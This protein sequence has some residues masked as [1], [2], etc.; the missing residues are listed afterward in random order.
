MDYYTIIGGDG[1]EYGP[2]SEDTIRDWIRQGRANALT[3]ASKGD[4]APHPLSEFP[5]FSD[6]LGGTVGASPTSGIKLSKSSSSSGGGML[7]SAQS[8]GGFLGES[9]PQ[10][11]AAVVLSEPLAQAGF[12]LKLMAVL[13]FIYGIVYAISV[14]G[15]F[16]AWLPIWMGVIMWQAANSARDAVALGDEALALRAQKKIKLLIVI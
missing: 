15:L 5:E 10:E 14:V 16:F 4:E 7:A 11:P 3:K 12:W 1:N 6:V 13:S 9:R 8:S 2:V